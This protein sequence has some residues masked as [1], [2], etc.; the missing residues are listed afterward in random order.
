MINHVS[1]TTVWVLDQDRAKEFYTEKL[2]LELRNDV[3][4]GGEF[5]G[6]GQGFRWLTVGP[7]EQPGVELILA[8]CAMGHDPETTE[9]VRELVAKGALGPG[10]LSTPDCQK[11]YE[12]LS[13]R[14]VV[15]VQEPAQRPYG[16][17]AVFRDDSG[18]VFS[19][20]QAYHAQVAP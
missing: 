14:G 5:E 13:A 6:A 19:L 15:F 17:E 8:D 18:N 11:A 1:H 2:G 9:Q 3:V 7:T 4:M 16:I 20:T 12:Q 10:V